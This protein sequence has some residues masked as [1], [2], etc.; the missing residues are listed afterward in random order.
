MNRK[1]AFIQCTK[2]GH[3][4]CKCDDIYSEKELYDNTY[5]M[6]DSFFME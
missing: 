2:C 4:S 5:N 3:I 6:D 1:K